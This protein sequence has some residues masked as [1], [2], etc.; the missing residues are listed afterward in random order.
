[1]TKTFTW[2]T[3]IRSPGRL[4]LTN[5]SRGSCSGAAGTTGTAAEICGMFDA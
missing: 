3:S 4:N 1:M 5:L 2:R